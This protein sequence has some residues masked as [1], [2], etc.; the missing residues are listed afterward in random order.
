[1]YML[2]LQD[3]AAP[4]VW[5]QLLHHCA[6]DEECPGCG[7]PTHLQGLVQQLVSHR[8]LSVRLQQQVSQQQ[9]QLSAQQQLITDLQRQLAVQQQQQL[10]ALEELTAQQHGELCDDLQKQL[11]LAQR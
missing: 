7:W 10:A 4:D 2:F 1:M 3:Q 5:L 9:A 8:D 11:Q 6:E